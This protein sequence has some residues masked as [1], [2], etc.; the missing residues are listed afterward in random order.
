MLFN[1]IPQHYT[2]TTACIG[3]VYNLGSQACVICAILKLHYQLLP[4]GIVNGGTKQPY[5]S[6]LEFN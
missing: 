1:S 5:S 4:T 6:H 3:F 2:A